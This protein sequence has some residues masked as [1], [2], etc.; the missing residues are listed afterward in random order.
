MLDLPT[1]TKTVLRENK[2]QGILP[3]HMLATLVYMN[4]FVT[5]VYLYDISN[6]KFQI[7]QYFNQQQHYQNSQYLCQHF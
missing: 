3:K 6:M 1:T 5:D 2:F 7:N 4:R